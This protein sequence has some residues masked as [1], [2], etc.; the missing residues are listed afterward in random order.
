MGQYFRLNGLTGFFIAVALLLS[1]LAV[2][3]TVSIGIQQDSATNYYK[4]NQD[5]TALKAIDVNNKD[6]YHLVGNN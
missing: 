1:I 6:H 3:V 5:T 2:L 4:I